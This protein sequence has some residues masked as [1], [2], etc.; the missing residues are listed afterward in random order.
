MLGG[1]E[2]AA[3]GVLGGWGWVIEHHLL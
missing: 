3:A 2:D 1:V